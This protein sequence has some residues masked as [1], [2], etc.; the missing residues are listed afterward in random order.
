MN[1]DL[2]QELGGS[3]SKG[4]V[5]PGDEVGHFSQTVYAWP[6]NTGS[7]SMKCRVMADQVLAG[8][9]RGTRVSRDLVSGILV[10][11]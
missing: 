9:S 5:V 6:L 3:V 1:H 11:A 4:Q 10:H 8:V 2:H 7:P